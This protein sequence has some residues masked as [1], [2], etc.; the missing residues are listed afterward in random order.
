MK[1]RRRPNV[2]DA[3]RIADM[4]PSSLWEVFEWGD[5]PAALSDTPDIEIHQ[6][7]DE[8]A[9]VTLHTRNGDVTAMLGDWVIRDEHGT[10]SSCDPALFAA[11]Y[12]P[13]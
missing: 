11:T 10:L 2:V 12:E 6:P 1:Y 9:T 3:V 13:A 5:G 4:K 7:G 8:Q